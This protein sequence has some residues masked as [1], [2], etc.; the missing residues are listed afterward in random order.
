[1][2]SVSSK[3]KKKSV[4]HIEA[5]AASKEKYLYVRLTAE[6]NAFIDKKTKEKGVSRAA[7]MDAIIDHVRTTGMI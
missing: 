1:M 7:L 6:N 5:P 2:K 4:I 3:T